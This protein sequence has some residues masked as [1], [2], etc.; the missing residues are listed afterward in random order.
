MAHGTGRC[1]S[2][3]GTGKK[4]TLTIGPQARIRDRVR[5]HRLL[6]EEAG[7]V[8]HVSIRESRDDSRHNLGTARC[9]LERPKLPIQIRRVLPGE[10][11][12]LSVCAIPVGAVAGRAFAGYHARAVFRIAD[13]GATRPEV[14][15]PRKP[16]Q[17]LSE[18]EE[19]VRSGEKRRHAQCDH[20]LRVHTR[21]PRNS[22]LHRCRHQAANIA[23]L[24]PISASLE[25]SFREALHENS[26]MELAFPASCV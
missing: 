2:T 17:H 9:G 5:V 12:I 11:R 3:S 10:L 20:K 13:G 19:R 14:R 7:G 8:S 25:F 22:R 23:P 15:L 18:R 24:L 21:D 4:D 26:E 6:A 1:P 16:G